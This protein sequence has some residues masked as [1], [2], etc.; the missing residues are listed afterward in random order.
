VVFTLSGFGSLDPATSISN[1]RFQYGTALNEGDFGGDDGGGGEEIPDGGTT[2]A[3]LG[4]AL[5]SLGGL[6]SRFARK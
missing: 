2:V 5:V 3:L 6:R 1:I 4:L